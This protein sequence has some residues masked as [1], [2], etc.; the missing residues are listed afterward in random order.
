MTIPVPPAPPLVT[1]PELPPP[2]VLAVPGEPTDNLVA[3][4]PPPIPPTPVQFALL[5]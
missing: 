2:P 5:P 4:A 3:F 1:Y